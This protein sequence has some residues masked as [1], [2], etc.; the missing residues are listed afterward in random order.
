MR[1]HE[2]YTS[3]PTTV[4]P[5]LVYTEYMVWHSFL[6][7][8]GSDVFDPD[9]YL[10]TFNQQVYRLETKIELIPL[11]A[12][13]KE[14]TVNVPV[15]NGEMPSVLKTLLEHPE[16]D[17]HLLGADEWTDKR[18]EVEKLLATKLTPEHI[19][20]SA[21]ERAVL[22][23]T[24]EEYVNWVGLWAMARAEKH[25]DEIREMLKRKEGPL[26][27]AMWDGSGVGL[28]KAWK[29][30]K[31]EWEKMEKGRAG[32]EYDLYVRRAEMVRKGN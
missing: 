22:K 9:F 7:C 5:V 8:E 31:E 1:L 14:G 10:V 20:Q 26:G 13:M 12:C 30:Y 27:S 11:L 2:Y 6:L 23:N 19:Y 24:R 15:K 28:E 25:W 17:W 3:F 16:L 21:K 29:E 4:A 18:K 32:R